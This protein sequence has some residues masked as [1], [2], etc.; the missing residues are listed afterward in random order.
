MP[1]GV[2]A[3]F[4][5]HYAVS[6]SKEFGGGICNL[7]WHIGKADG[8]PECKK[9]QTGNNRVEAREEFRIGLAIIVSVAIVVAITLTTLRLF[10]L[11]P[12]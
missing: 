11:L 1:I 6:Y 2:F 3:F 5:R 4:T 7:G 8:C 10:Q 12:K 9:E